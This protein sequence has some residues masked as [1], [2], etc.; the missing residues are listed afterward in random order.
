MSIWVLSLQSLEPGEQDKE[1]RRRDEMFGR[2]CSISTSAHTTAHS[3]TQ[4]KLWASQLELTESFLM[5]NIL[6]VAEIKNWT[7]PTPYVRSEPGAQISCW[8]LSR[9][10]TAVLTSKTT[11]TSR[12]YIPDQS[13]KIQPAAAQSCYHTIILCLTH[14]SS[15]GKLKLGFFN[16]LDIY[17]LNKDNSCR[18]YF[19]LSISLFICR[20]KIH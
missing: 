20:T 12:G 3:S 15:Q 17:Y 7:S 13:Y 1:L 2:C 6:T 19:S 8:S 10:H 9:N 14:Q 16:G 4:L 5:W 11:I 18:W